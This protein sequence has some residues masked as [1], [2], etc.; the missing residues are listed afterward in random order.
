MEHSIHAET[1][2]P[3]TKIKEGAL[4]M[5]VQNHCPQDRW[6]ATQNRKP[7]FLPARGT[8]ST[9]WKQAK[10]CYQSFHSTLNI[11]SFTATHP[12]LSSKHCVLAW[13][14]TEPEEKPDPGQILF[15]RAQNPANTL[16]GHDLILTQKTRQEKMNVPQ[17]SNPSWRIK[18]QGK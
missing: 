14:T 16:M 17:R 8:L 10:I 3:S 4:F 11:F 13:L 5:V 18:K 1:Q 15:P 2:L 7:L 9:T 12:I 6:G